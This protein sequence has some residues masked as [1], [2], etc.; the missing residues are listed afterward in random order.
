MVTHNCLQQVELVSHL[1]G[2]VVVFILTEVVPPAGNTVEVLVDADNDTGV[3]SVG[4]FRCQYGQHIICLKVRPTSTV[5]GV[6]HPFPTCLQDDRLERGS[7]VGLVHGVEFTA[8]VRTVTER[9]G[10]G[11]STKTFFQFRDPFM[12]VVLGSAHVSVKRP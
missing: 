8:I 10:C 2:W 11:L 4:S 12:D 5:V 3:Q 1:H 6:H 9:Y 7:S